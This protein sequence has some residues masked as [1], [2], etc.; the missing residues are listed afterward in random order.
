MRAKTKC[1]N[2]GEIVEENCEACIKGG[3]LWHSCG[4]DGEPDVYDVEWKIIEE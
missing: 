2:C 1:P 4:K 3:S